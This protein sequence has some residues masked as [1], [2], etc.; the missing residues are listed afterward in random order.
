MTFHPGEGRTVAAMATYTIGQAA[1]HVGLPTTTLRFWERRGLLEPAG[2]T[3]AGY[4]FYDDAS[5]HRIAFIRQA[6]RLGCSL[7]EVADL[8]AVAAGGECAPVQSRLHDLVTEKVTEARAVTAE[9]VEFTSRLESAVARL[10][11]EPVVGACRDGCACLG[12]SGHDPGSTA[13]TVAPDRE[14]GRGIACTLAPD[15]VPGR[16]DRWRDLLSHVVGRESTPDGALRLSLAPGTPLERLVHLTADEQRCCAF[17]AFAVT[18][19]DRGIA[20][21]VRAPD[22][23]A[24][25][26]EALFGE[27]PT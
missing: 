22:Q 17:F 2:R 24:E 5:V 7:D 19:D 23:A 6:K 11:R 16:L 21:E 14:G 9:M 3:E 20:L 27:R 4:R 8:L 10:A 12:P 15:Q 18:L 26:V 25:I 1:E 13:W